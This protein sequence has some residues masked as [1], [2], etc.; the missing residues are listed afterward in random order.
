M[1]NQQ[2]RRA[3]HEP[4]YHRARH[5]FDHA[6]RWAVGG[7]LYGLLEILYRGHTHWTMMVLAALLCVPLDI[8]NEHIPWEWPLWVQAI[9][10]G[11]IVTA[12]EFAAGL[13]LN[14]WLKLGIWDYSALW[15]N[16]LG[17]ICPQFWAVWCLLACPVIVAFDW[18][19]Y[20][21]DRAG[22]ERP[23]Y[24]YTR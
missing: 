18:L 3:E 11:S 19:C 1:R 4:A 5:L 10:G 23:H 16:L 21:C 9:A 17:Q 7:C 20:L 22:H 15:G 24:T 14:I 2:M 8:A 6:L 13:I 12:A